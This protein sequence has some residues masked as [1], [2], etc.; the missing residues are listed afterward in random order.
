MG[1]IDSIVFAQALDNPVGGH[2]MVEQSIHIPCLVLG[3]IGT[4]D[5]AWVDIDV[6]GERHLVQAHTVYVS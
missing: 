4:P 2:W 5:G 6:Q 3:I 1:K